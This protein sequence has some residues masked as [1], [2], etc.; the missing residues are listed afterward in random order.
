MLNLHGF[1]CVLINTSAGKDSL[2]MLDYLVELATEQSF[3]ISKMVAVHA[4]LGRVEWKGT[5]DLAKRQ[6]ARYGMRFE[7]IA[8]PQGDLL[9]HIENRGKFP[10]MQNRYCTSDHKR[11]QIQKVLTMLHREHIAATGIKTFRVLNCMG[12]RA[13]ESSARAKKAEFEYDA[14]GTTKNRTVTIWHPILSWTV[15]EVWERIK[16]R[17]LEYHPAYNLGM[18]R[19]SCI[20][21]V[22]AP[23]AALMIA[24]KH[25][26]E[27]LDEYVRVE[28]K[29]GHTFKNG[30][31]IASLKTEIDENPNI[32][33]TVEETAKW[34]M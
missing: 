9:T 16:I 6:V 4:D 12:L 32:I 30:W 28:K 20:F 26:P 5:A 8:R 17:K 3:P 29:I 19:L 10:D 22:F 14:L 7:K 21:C 23:K 34:N 18:P 11:G 2:A 15:E 31:K 27:L 25:N 13:Q 24:G 33:I 1:D